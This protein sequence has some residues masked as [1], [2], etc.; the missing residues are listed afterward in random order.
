MV[1]KEESRA[2]ADPKAYNRRLVLW[3]A[4]GYGYLFGILF[5]ALFL[6]G[7]TV[8]L[9]IQS[10]SA[11][12]LSFKVVAFLGVVVF[13]ILR[14]LW[15][16]IDMPDGVEL[17]ESEYPRLFQEVNS[18]ANR[19]GAPVPDKIIVDHE[20]NAAAA[21]IPRLGVFGAYRNVLVLGLPL[22]AT[23]DPDELRS[24]VAHEFGHFSGE[25]GKLGVWVYRSNETWQQLHESLNRHG[26]Y[27]VMLFRWFFNWYSPR[28]AATTFASR[29][30]HEYEADQTAARVATPQIA[31]RTLAKLEYLEA[32]LDEK[33][34][35]ET[36]VRGRNEPQMPRDLFLPLTTVRHEPY[37]K[38]RAIQRIRAGLRDVTGYGDTH[39]ALSDR[40]RALGVLPEKP[41]DAWFEAIV[42]PP[43][44]TAAEEFLGE[45]FSSLCLQLGDWAVE[46]GSERWQQRQKEAEAAAARAAEIAGKAAEGELSPGE[47]VEWAL[48][49]YRSKGFEP[50]EPLM[51][52]CVDDGIADATLLYYL[53][54]ECVKRD[55]EEGVVL[56]QRSSELDPEF[57]PAAQVQLAGFYRLRGQEEKLQEVRERSIEAHTLLAIDEEASIR[58]ELGDEFV[59]TDL[60]DEV[61]TSLRQN[62]SGVKGLAQAFVA[63]K[64]LPTGRTANVV[65]VVP[66][67][68]TFSLS[69][70]LNGLSERVV[71][72]CEDVEARVVVFA[73]E[74]WK[75]WIKRMKQVPNSDLYSAP[76]K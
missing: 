26:G 67:V 12:Y 62:L 32:L 42:L 53:G 29:R 45:R 24:V 25:H 54:F 1:R 6:M 65:I 19:L 18:I 28:Y 2:N 71:K 75:P 49:T 68:S 63:R 14:S 37:N 17:R 41:D 15:V 40:L 59:P 56:L 34:F 27:G 30:A 13:F 73:P 33:F 16:R 38:E 66:V 64:V 55:R 47:R 44:R 52:A 76:K 10:R 4:L 60:P 5:L 43:E 8:Y 57:A 74:S 46:H 7:L 51:Q 48:T 70:D 3:T 72:V 35:E 23:L 58:F 39:P 69:T 20:L 21:Q 50:A 9:A 31:G 11:G 22:M 36:A 61:L